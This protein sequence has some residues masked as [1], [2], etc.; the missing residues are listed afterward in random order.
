MNEFITQEKIRKKMVK[1]AEILMDETNYNLKNVPPLPSESEQMIKFVYGKTQ[2]IP[3]D[4]SVVEPPSPNTSLKKANEYLLKLTNKGFMKST[5]L[6]RDDP[7]R[8]YSLR[9]K[10][11]NV[12][13]NNVV[14]RVETQA[15]NT[16]N[17][18][19]M[20]NYLT[21][22]KVVKKCFADIQSLPF[23][24]KND[25]IIVTNKFVSRVSSLAY[26]MIAN[27]SFD[28]KKRKRQ[29][30]QANT[31]KF[32]KNVSEIRNELIQNAFSRDLI[33]ISGLS[34][35]A[36][37]EF[38]NLMKLDEKK[39]DLPAIHTF[40][41]TFIQNF[42][43]DEYS[44]SS[45]DEDEKDQQIFQRAFD[46]STSI[47]E[48]IP[49]EYRP[50]FLFPGESLKVL[51]KKTSQIRNDIPQLI[52]D[53]HD[54]RPK[55]TGSI[56]QSC[57][58]PQKSCRIILNTTRT[59]IKEPTVDENQKNENQEDL[60]SA[61]SLRET[62]WKGDD[63]LKDQ[64]IQNETEPL[65]TFQKLSHIVPIEITPIELIDPPLPHIYID[66]LYEKNRIK[67]RIERRKSKTQSSMRLIQTPTIHSENNTYKSTESSIYDKNTERNAAEFLA[68]HSEFEKGQSEIHNRLNEIWDKLGFSIQQK[69]EMVLKYSKDLDESTR[70][71][72]ALDLWEQAYLTIIQYQT[73]YLALKDFLHI[74][75]DTI[76]ER[77]RVFLEQI[78]LELHNSEEAVL[79]IGHLLKQNCGDELIIKR[80]KSNDLIES[81]RMN[82][83]MRL[84]EM[85]LLSILKPDGH[86]HK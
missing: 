73:C 85:G 60:F 29:Q 37:T 20:Y 10:K 69:L 16:H 13:Q 86:S 59:T 31:T 35:Q 3:L 1:R 26:G 66:S 76:R 61:R 2:D 17:V 18:S 6:S 81:R 70:L 33:N 21:S 24:L 12:T 41:N 38:S 45:H 50:S 47:A 36:K 9:N 71:V 68:S 22:M 72:D 25:E 74:E 42:Y 84:S 28:L 32:V 44:D 7:I 39:S 67:N 56:A 79:N 46:E 19:P 8:V 23:K 51:P 15:N 58:I 11:T 14:E 53:S 52:I 49:R 54:K 40:H 62:Y 80:K 65:P 82:L 64:R 5:T 43:G 63:P 4:D 27:G 34:P 75:S 83:H 78:L 30:L 77:K 48:K 55:T 57:S